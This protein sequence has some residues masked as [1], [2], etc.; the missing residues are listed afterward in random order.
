MVPRARDVLLVLLAGAA[1]SV[2]ALSYLRLG[3]VFT[4]NMTGNA[5]LL[6]IAV[7]EREGARVL[8]SVLALGGFALGV[9]AGAALCGRGDRPEGRWSPRVTLAIGIELL[10]LL[11]F[12]AGWAIAGAP[13][14]ARRCW[15][16]GPCSRRWCRSYW[17]PRWSQPPDRPPCTRRRSTLDQGAGIWGTQ[18]GPADDRCDLNSNSSWLDR[19]A[20]PA[21]AYI[22]GQHLWI[23]GGWSAQ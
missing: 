13:G 12:A 10:V 4:A 16:G 5:V 21:A 9:L 19:L 2:D 22:T 6:G 14:S 7:G 18:R 23:G 8:R 1:G 17:S 3:N 11:G 15:L 20:S